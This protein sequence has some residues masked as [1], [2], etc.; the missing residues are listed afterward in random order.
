[1]IGREILFDEEASPNYRLREVK[2]RR[3]AE[4]SWEVVEAASET[5]VVGGLADREEALR[6]VRAWERLSQ[7]LEGGLAGHVLVH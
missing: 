5:T 6:I 2:R 7:R 3:T 4:T 1:M